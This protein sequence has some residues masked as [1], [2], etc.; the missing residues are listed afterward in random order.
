[1]SGVE[2]DAESL[3]SLE[4]VEDDGELFDRAPDRSPGA[5]RVLHQQPRSFVAPVEDLCERRDDTIE[6]RLETGA[7]MRAHVEDD[8][9]R[10]DRACRIDGGTHRLDAL[11]IDRVVRSAEI[12]EVERV[13]GRKQARLLASCAKLLEVRRIVVR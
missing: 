1:M 6:A 5:R 2:T 8:G 3:V 4:R 12:H 7:E 11:G 9:V 10:L 13:Y